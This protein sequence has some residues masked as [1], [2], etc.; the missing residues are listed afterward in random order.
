MENSFYYIIGGVLLL[1]YGWKKNK[2]EEVA[3]KAKRI[4]K[5]DKKL[6]NYMK[7]GLKEYNWDNKN[8]RFSKWIDA[9]DKDVLFEN[10]DV[11]VYKVK[12]FVEYRLGFYIKDTE[13]YG[14][15]SSWEDF[16]NFYRSDS[17]FTKEEHLMYDD[18]D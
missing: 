8:D 3:E 7:Q 4:F 9:K 13:E 5:R 11:V 2:Q 12:H 15:Y 14:L 6:Y 1:Y 18:D 17:T 16:E 10:I